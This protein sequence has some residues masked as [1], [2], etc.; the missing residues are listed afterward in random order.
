MAGI[1]VRDL[2]SIIEAAYA[3][4]GSTED[5]LDGVMDAM[6]DTLGD[7]GRAVAALYDATK[8]DWVE[9]VGARW[10]NLPPEF[11]Q[12][13]FNQPPGTPSD[14]RRLVQTFRKLAFG[15]VNEDVLPIVHGF[16]EL[17]PR[18]GV[19][20]LACVNATDPTFRG[21]LICLPRPV[22]KYPARV[23]YVWRQLAAHLAAG[24][25]LRRVLATL[26]GAGDP[27]NQAEAVLTSDGRAAHATGPARSG[28]ARAALKESLVRIEEA[29]ASRRG[30]QTKAVDMWRGLCAGRWSLVEHFERDGRRY[31]LAYRND[32]AL[33]R[34]RALT[35]RERQ[36]C[37]Y[38]AMG[39]SNKLI[40]Y[41]LGLSP[42]AVATHLERARRKLGR[43]A[44]LATLQ[45]LLGDRTN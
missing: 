45:A 18:Y 44:T 31:F 23:R 7:G 12:Q 9:I 19:Q 20:D 11:V 22:T 33:A 3:L 34:A 43:K 21:C 28:A 6:A 2:V 42:P 36:V 29:R 30:D 39:H 25:R 41:S 26:A 17:L 1:A 13:L 40:A 4:D 5:W 14:S 38:A 16:R 8:P 27:T 15:T 24:M 37:T 10:R 35:A 32:P